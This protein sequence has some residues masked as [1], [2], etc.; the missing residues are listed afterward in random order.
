M[1]LVKVQLKQIEAVTI[2]TAV[3]RLNYGDA[4]WWRGAI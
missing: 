3:S 4:T 1:T 2:L